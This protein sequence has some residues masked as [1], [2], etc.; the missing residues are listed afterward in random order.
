MHTIKLASALAAGLLSAA[1]ASADIVTLDFSGTGGNG[2]S[3]NNFYNGGTD[4]TGTVGYSNY[5]ISFASSVLVVPNSDGDGTYFS[6]SVPG[7]AT[8]VANAVFV[9]PAS[10]PGTPAFMNVATGFDSFSVAYSGI[11]GATDT[12]LNFYSGVNGAG[13][14][15]G[16]KSLTSNSDGCAT[17]QACIW[18]VAT[19]DLGGAIAQSVD[20]SSNASNI[21]FT[22]VS[23]NVVPLPASGLLMSFGVAGLALFGVRRRAA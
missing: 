10:L 9:L 6:G 14:F 23:V 4:S 21:L 7:S 12:V 18:T 1:T 13:T 20:F 5:G 22:N 2:A 3:V 8:P 16:S 15:L 11:T 17:G 19:M